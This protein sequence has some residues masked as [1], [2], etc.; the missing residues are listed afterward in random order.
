MYWSLA[1][2][3]LLLPS[4]QVVEQMRVVVGGDSNDKDDNKDDD[5]TTKEQTNNNKLSLLDWLFTCWDE[6]AGG[7]GGNTG[8]SAHLLYTLSAVQ[9]LALA[10]RLDDARL[11]RERLVHF[12][13]TLQQPDGSFAGDAWG[14]VDT[15]F[16]YCALSTLSLLGRL[17]DTVDVARAAHYILQCRNLDGGFGCVIGAESHAGM[18]ENEMT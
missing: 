17:D 1:G 2:L 8:Q 4:D 10:D 15:R 13:A 7:F 9:I 16:T 12:V 5:D 11:Q 14:E 18:Y 3:S 6:V